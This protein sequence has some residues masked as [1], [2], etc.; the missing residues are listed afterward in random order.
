MEIV[1]L[2]SNS[3]K[4]KYLQQ[5]LDCEW[6]AGKILAKMILSGKIEEMCKDNPRVF[7]LVKDDEIISFCTYVHQDEINALGI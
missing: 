4:D 2:M 1:E 5:L 6:W 3:K 7:M